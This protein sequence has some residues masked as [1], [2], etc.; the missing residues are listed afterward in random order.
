L[1]IHRD[2][3][4][5]HSACEKEIGYGQQAFY[6]FK[7]SKKSLAHHYRMC[8]ALFLDGTIVIAIKRKRLA[9]RGHKA[10]RMGV[11]KTLPQDAAFLVFVPL[12]GAYAFYIIQL[13]RLARCAK[14]VLS[15]EGKVRL[16]WPKPYLL[17]KLNKA[18]AL[19]YIYLLRMP[20]AFSF[21]SP[22]SPENRISSSSLSRPNV[23]R[24]TFKCFCHLPFGI[25]SAFVATTMRG[26][27]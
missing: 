6:P 18:I 11:T 12:I 1:A 16:P 21:P 24:V 9:S 22:V 20:H 13:H 26:R 7:R 5:N 8:K 17:R 27:S 25:L 14:D 23:S 2:A 19:F 3:D 4:W 10:P 15:T